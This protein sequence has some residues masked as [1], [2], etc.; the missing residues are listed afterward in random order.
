MKS[1]L[2]A[3]AG[4]LAAF[5]ALAAGETPA[6]KKVLVVTATTGFRHSSIPTAENVLAT[7]G[8]TS[9]SYTVVDV[10]RGGPDGKDEAEV[11]QKL[12]MENLGKVDGVIFANTT[13]D[14]AIPDKEG[15]I[16]WVE[17]GHALIG[18]HSCSDTLHGF[19]AFVELVGGEFLTHGAQVSVDMYNQDR[20][21]PATKHLGGVWTMF[22]EIYEFKN[23]HRRRVHGLLT[24]DKHPQTHIGGDFPVAWAKDLKD[25]GRMFYTSLGHREDVWTSAT[26]QQHIL[27]GIR[28]A[29]GIEPGSG[30][31]TTP[32][33]EILPHE[34]AEGFKL[35]FDG[36]SLGGWKYRR[37]DGMKSW[38]VQNGMLC[39]VLK[40]DKDG[41][42]TE[43][44]TDI[45][46]EQ[47][48][49][50]FVLRYDYQI[51]PKSNSGLYLRGRHEIQIL[52]DYASGK[53]S[54][55]GNGA[56]YN[57]QP[58]SIFASRKAGQW[59]SVEARMVGNRI[60]V[61]LNGVLVHDGVV[62]DKGT[63]SHLDDDVASPGPIL[64]QG[65]HGAVAFRNI[66]IRRL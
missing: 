41:N 23:F 65:D 51:A 1:H 48:F 15:F 36:L 27:G 56:I 50:D 46:S 44:G 49:R 6:P 57:V 58:V 19:P 24:L 18:M 45:Y 32:A 22:D 35:L 52:D 43:H 39:N 25:G 55:G 28:W 61:I 30:R 53:P 66:R 63:G 5:A 34:H 11:A 12:S 33:N 64:L 10:V 20:T 40:T 9:G 16:R 60:T 26:Y 3:A 38:S 21:H 59:Q 7:L 29:L 4:L 17:K 31:A 47:K 2:H 13:G 8:M 42:F 37:E 14:L 54:P 62:C